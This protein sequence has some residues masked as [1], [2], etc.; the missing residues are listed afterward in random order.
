[1][2][3]DARVKENLQENAIE[4]ANWK[5]YKSNGISYYHNTKIK[6]TQLECPQDFISTSTTETDA[7]KAAAEAGKNTC[8]YLPHLLFYTI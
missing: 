2:T 4:A 6:V 1:M 3:D 8:Y 7:A 5:T